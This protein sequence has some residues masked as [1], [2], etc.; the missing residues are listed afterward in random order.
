[1]AYVEKRGA[2][3]VL[4]RGERKEMGYKY[5]V[6]DQWVFNLD[7]DYTDFSVHHQ[8]Y[9]LPRRYKPFFSFQGKLLIVNA[10]YCWDGASGPT[11]DSASV[12]ASSLFHDC[13]YQAMRLRYLPQAFR[14]IADED[15]RSLLESEG[16]GWLRRG[17]YYRGVRI[18]GRRSAKP[19]VPENW[20][21]GGNH[22]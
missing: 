5:T 15:F 7:N 19:K 12:M 6:R 10:P 4:L 17:Y 1:M 9:D 14:E 2:Y 13:A 3:D 21:D 18:G 20:D 8:R 11:I 16:M 22:V